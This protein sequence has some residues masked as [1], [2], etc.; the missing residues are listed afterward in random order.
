MK[1]GW[2]EWVLSSQLPSFRK[3][4]DLHTHSLEVAG[5]SCIS[6]VT[7]FPPWGVHRLSG[8]FQPVSHTDCGVEALIRLF[9]LSL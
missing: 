3:Q 2:G 1:L 5:V 4:R 7:A 8:R 9:V 6:A